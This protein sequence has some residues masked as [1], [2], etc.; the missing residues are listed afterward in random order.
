MHAIQATQA[1]QLGNEAAA[2]KVIDARG[3][4]GMLHTIANACFTPRV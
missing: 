3:G 2:K 1:E 4:S